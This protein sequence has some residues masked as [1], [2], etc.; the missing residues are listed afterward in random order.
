M[1]A[2][3]KT[4]ARLVVSALLVSVVGMTL[5]LLVGRGLARRIAAERVA[6]VLVDAVPAEG[7]DACRRGAPRATRASEALGFD[8]YSADGMPLSP[9]AEE[10]P[11]DLM[12]AIRGSRSA[13]VSEVGAA[14]MLL[15]L[16]GAGACAYA[17]AT[18]RYQRRGVLTS[19][20]W[21]LVT[22]IVLSAALGATGTLLVARPLVA[23]LGELRRAAKSLGRARSGPHV[24]PYREP[25]LVLDEARDVVL[26]LREADA[27]IGE[28]SARLFERSET[29]E[30]LLG[31]LTHDIATPLASLQFA[32]DEVADVAPETALPALRRALSDVVYVKSLT[33]NLRL[34]ERLAPDD[35]RPLALEDFDVGEV[36]RAVYERTAPFALRR[37]IEVDVGTFPRTTVR[38]DSTATERALTNLL[39]NAIAYGAP[40][41][42]VTVML[43]GDVL[44]VE[45]DG[46]GVRPED[47][48][49]LG[50]RRFRASRDVERDR[51]RARDGKGSGLGL[52]IVQEVCARSGWS[53]RFS[54]PDAGGF[55]AEITFG[56]DHSES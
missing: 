52:A 2:R 44:A 48:P 18:W 54:I 50:T 6:E 4:I 41:A 43:E 3:P 40:G 24:A 11:A 7:I 37:G 27:R 51:V 8:F 42:R 12:T 53:L 19:G 36:I 45:D 30:A 56:R 15:R 49:K 5:A 26:V 16:E 33:D 28:S 32:L 35:G 46:P 13:A 22:M 10:I 17:Q 20:G 38:G 21:L 9:G 47:L 1:N 25:R 34:A 31:E 14:K 39:E 23:Q 55:R 29:L